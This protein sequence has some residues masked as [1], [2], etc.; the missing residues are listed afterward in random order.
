MIDK[1]AGVT[2]HDVV[3]MLR[4]RFHERQVG[5]GGTLDPDATGV[6]VVAIG[7]ATR[8]LRFVEATTKQYAGE[9][10]LGTATSTLDSSGEVT[11]SW[12]MSGVTVDDARRVV[13][14][15]LSGDIEQVPP[16]VS[17]LKVDGV[18]LHELA[19]Q[20]IEVER[21]PRPIH[22]S[23]FDVAEGPE[24]G[25]LAIDVECSPGTYIRSL[26]D[27]LGRLLGGGAHL[28]NLRRTA[29]GALTVGQAGN[30]DEAELLP[31]E[32]AVTGLTRVAV[33]DEVA[34]LI[35]TGRV[36][37][38]AEH[39]FVGDGPW[40]VFG[41]AGLLAVYERFEKGDGLVKPAVVLPVGGSD[42]VDR[43]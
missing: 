26:A 31:V 41:P 3:G 6:L 13:A 20:G 1:P 42:P 4:R 15:H 43:R 14:E 39:G 24:P 33:G 27:D 23:R 21:A 10:V 25:V 19:R 5:H 16:M 11:G 36:L 28:R 38:A 22:I 40:A 35:G 17:A 34:A 37:H 9:V 12:D 7:M 29:V 32:T 8:L 2:S 30:P 18:R